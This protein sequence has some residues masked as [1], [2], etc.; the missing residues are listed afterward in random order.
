MKLG[1]AI[2]QLMR[3][4]TRIPGGVE[5]EVHIWVCDGSSILTTT[6]FEIDHAATINTDTGKASEYFGIIKAHPHRDP[7]SRTPPRRHGGR[8]RVP[9]AVGRGGQRLT[10]STSVKRVAPPGRRVPVAAAGPGHGPVATGSAGRAGCRG[11]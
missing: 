7:N 6:D 8:R 4:A 2:E 10:G 3:V 5:A 11:R 9:A 1:D